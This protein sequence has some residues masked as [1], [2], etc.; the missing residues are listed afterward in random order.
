MIRLLK[1]RY[2]VNNISFATI[3]YIRKI[4]CFQ[5]MNLADIVVLPTESTGIHSNL[6]CTTVV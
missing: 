3:V 6:C 1:E 5:H 2:I 4:G